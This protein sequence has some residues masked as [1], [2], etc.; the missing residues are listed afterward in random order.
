VVVQDLLAPSVCAPN[1]TAIVVDVQLLESHILSG[2]RC[3]Y[4]RIQSESAS[5]L[6]A[7]LAP[8]TQLRPAA[9]RLLQSNRPQLMGP[10][11]PLSWLTG[12]M[13]AQG[14]ARGYASAP[15]H[16]LC[17][18]EVTFEDSALA[19]EIAQLQGSTLD[20]VQQRAR[21]LGM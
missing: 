15:T 7:L 1:C 18:L 12:E 8:S 4:V 21:G 17:S 14:F 3:A 20:E 9:V 5:E 10:L 19:H 6:A 11:A 13:P 2:W 16:L